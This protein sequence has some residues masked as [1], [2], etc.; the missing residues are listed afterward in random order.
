M[1]V[2]KE[3]IYLPLLIQGFF[4]F[5]FAIYSYLGQ[6]FVCLV[7]PTAT[8][9][10][11]CSVFIGLNNFFSGLIVRPQY[12]VGGFYAIPYYI[13]PGHYV[14]EGLVMSIFSNDERNVIANEGSAFYNYLVAK[15]DPCVVGL[16]ERCNG[17]I[18]EYVNVFFGFEYSA[19]NFRRN[20]CIL[21]FILLLAR[22]LTWIALKYIRFAS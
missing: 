15:D 12:L 4:T 10:I 9:I 21:G 16:E 11:L 17:T 6:L 3:L 22:V 18:S 19:D 7:K 13:T 2:E 20:A 14:Y 5:N 8:A 1:H